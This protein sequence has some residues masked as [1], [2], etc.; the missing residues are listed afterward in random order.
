M[1]EIEMLKKEIRRL[2][3]QNIETWGFIEILQI[4]M[5]NRVIEIHEIREEVKKLKDQNNLPESGIWTLEP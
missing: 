5:E 1:K 4:K 3:E 2:K